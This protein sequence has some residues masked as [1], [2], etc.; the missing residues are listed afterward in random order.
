MISHKIYRKVQVNKNMRSYQGALI[1]F[2]GYAHVSRFPLWNAEVPILKSEE[3][4][5]MG[6]IIEIPG[7][8]EVSLSSTDYAVQGVTV[9]KAPLHEWSAIEIALAEIFDQIGYGDLIPEEKSG[10]MLPAYT[11]EDRGDNIFIHTVALL[12]RGKTTLA[13]RPT[14]KSYDEDFIAYKKQELGEDCYRLIQ[15]IF[16]TLD[17]R[18]AFDIIIRNYGLVIEKNNGDPLSPKQKKDLEDIISGCHQAP[19]NA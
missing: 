11:I 19:D 9:T 15:N 3:R 1:A 13:Y 4:Q 12:Y 5:L 6:R 16:R 7:V 18:Q 2:Q 10:R 17:A 8:E 14:W